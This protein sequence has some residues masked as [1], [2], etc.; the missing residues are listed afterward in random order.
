MT[1]EIPNDP[2]IAELR[3]I[4]EARAAQF[5]YDIEAM[6]KDLQEKQAK[7]GRTYVRLRKRP[8]AASNAAT[9]SEIKK[10]RS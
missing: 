7:S 4:R 8:A 1:K 2:I 3:A 9:A 6:F 10:S 5:N